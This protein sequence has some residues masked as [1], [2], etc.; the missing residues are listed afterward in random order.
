MKTLAEEL[1]ALGLQVAG[2]DVDLHRVRL[3]DVADV[4]EIAHR[5]LHW[6][7]SASAMKRTAS[8]RA[9]TWP[10]RAAAGVAAARAL[11]AN[12]DLPPKEIVQR[13]LSIAADICIYTNSNI[14]VLEPTV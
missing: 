13:G 1:A 10:G 11:V 4:G 3:A 6:T 14:T 12:T 7:S 5:Y 8:P 9:M 2:I